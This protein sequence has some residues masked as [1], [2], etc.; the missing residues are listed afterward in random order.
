M[1]SGCVSAEQE[2]SLKTGYKRVD[3]SFFGFRRSLNLTPHGY[4]VVEAP[5]PIRDGET[6]ERFEVRPGDC[7]EDAGW[8]DCATDRERSELYESGIIS[9]AGR[10]YWYGWSL[11]VPED[12][13]NVYRTKVT[14]GQFKQKEVGAPLVMFE[15]HTGGYWLD[16]NQ[17]IG[18]VSGYKKLIDKDDFRG[19]WHDI[20]VHAKWCTG[21]DG[22]VKVWVNGELKAEVNGRNTYYNKPIYFKYGVYRSYVS[23]YGAR[24]PTQIAYFDEV[25]KGLAREDVDLR[26][27]GGFGKES[28]RL[29][30]PPSDQKP[31]AVSSFG[32][33]LESVGNSVVRFKTAGRCQARDGGDAARSQDT[34]ERTIEEVEKTEPEQLPALTASLVESYLDLASA[35]LEMGCLD[36]AEDRFAKAVEAAA[37]PAHA[38]AHERAQQGLE[39][40]RSKRGN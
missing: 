26:L 30:W 31:S 2:A 14:L 8:S 5:H 13:P 34:L 37:D 19:K 15:N 9:Y 18:E 33:I 12:F 40:A 23:R 6:A 39:L 25:R 27:R 11:Y 32:R 4:Q 38:A 10:E 17:T 21:T 22:F 29:S 28:V 35:A 16:M 3:T 24:V 36:M 20:V 7:G 1:Q